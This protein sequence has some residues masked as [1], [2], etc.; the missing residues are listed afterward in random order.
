MFSRPSRYLPNLVYS[1]L[2]LS[3]ILI[4]SVG[5]YKSKLVEVV[6]MSIPKVVE[7]NKITAKNNQQ[8]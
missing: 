5:I 6:K 1:L 8:F 2:D 7:S 4:V 3:K